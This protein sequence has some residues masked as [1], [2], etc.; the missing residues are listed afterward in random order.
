M[1]R[2]SQSLNIGFKKVRRRIAG[3][4]IGSNRG[5]NG[6]NNRQSQ[7]DNFFS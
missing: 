2:I 1:F 7:K 6:Q 5:G 3:K 4:Y